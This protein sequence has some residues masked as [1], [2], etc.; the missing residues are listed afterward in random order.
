[1]KEEISRERSQASHEHAS[2]QNKVVWLKGKT[3]QL[4][5]KPDAY[6]SKPN[7][8]KDSGERYQLLFTLSING[9]RRYW[10]EKLPKKFGWRKNRIFVI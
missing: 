9:Q 4:S 10:T 8:Q 5:K 7:C 6:Y 2:L 1:M 3:G